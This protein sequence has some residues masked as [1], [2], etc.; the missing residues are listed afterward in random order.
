MER[1]SESCWPGCVKSPKHAFFALM[2]S[3][4]TDRN[5]PNTQRTGDSAQIGSGSAFHEK[6][7]W[8]PRDITGFL[9]ETRPIRGAPS[10]SCHGD[11]VC[12]VNVVMLA[13]S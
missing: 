8:S 7:C 5:G 13:R 1:M 12:R 10:V 6:L 11:G 4:A 3:L 9:G 2:G